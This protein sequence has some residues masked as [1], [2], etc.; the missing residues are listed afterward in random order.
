MTTGNRE[1]RQGGEGKEGIMEAK[2]GILGERW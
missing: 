1:E 2:V